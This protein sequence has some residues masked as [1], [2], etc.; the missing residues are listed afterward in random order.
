MN[1][2]SGGRAIKAMLTGAVGHRAAPGGAQ[3]GSNLAWKN[4]RYFG[5]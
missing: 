4:R 3:I 1:D 2:G 5:S